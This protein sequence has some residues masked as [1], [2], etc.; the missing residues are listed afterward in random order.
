MAR[1][2]AGFSQEELGALA[3]LHRTEV[4]MVEKGE[5]LPRV[6]T[7]LKLAAALAVPVGELVTGVEW[8]VPASTR[9]GT[10]AVA[11]G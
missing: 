10:F 5:R 8:I 3:G 2:R 6:D 7:L 9:P 11:G 1:R 4:G